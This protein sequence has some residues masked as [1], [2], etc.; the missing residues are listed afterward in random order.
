MTLEDEG[1]IFEAEIIR[2]EIEN[3]KT[4][5]SASSIEIF[6]EDVSH[7]M[8]NV[9]NNNVIWDL[10]LQTNYLTKHCKISEHSNLVLAT[11]CWCPCSKAM[12]PWRKHYKIDSIFCKEATKCSH[13]GICF[14]MCKAFYHILLT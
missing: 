13:K 4:S 1:D 2:D 5:G 14:K 12:T 8:T 11:Q 6:P 3:P 10:G 7:F 9:V